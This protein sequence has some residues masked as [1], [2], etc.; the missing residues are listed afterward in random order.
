MIPPQCSTSKDS[1]RNHVFTCR[2]VKLLRSVC[3]PFFLKLPALMPY[4]ISTWFRLLFEIIVTSFKLY[5]YLFPQAQIQFFQCSTVLTSTHKDWDTL[6]MWLL[7]TVNDHVT[8]FYSQAMIMWPFLHPLT[9]LWNCKLCILCSLDG[10]TIWCIL[11]RWLN[12]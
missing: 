7:F 10:A 9:M 6:I 11:M 5:S 4:S 1:V 12:N 3:F 2:P 8:P